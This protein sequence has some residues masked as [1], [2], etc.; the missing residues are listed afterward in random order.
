MLEPS[1]EK[2]AHAVLREERGREALDLPGCPKKLTSDS[3][4]LYT[5]DIDICI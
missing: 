5:L 1:A 3:Q 2:F 4:Y